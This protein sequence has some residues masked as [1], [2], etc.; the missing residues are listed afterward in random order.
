MIYLKNRKFEEAKI[1]I[2]NQ[3]E[4]TS[5]CGIV[6]TDKIEFYEQYENTEFELDRICKIC[7]QMRSFEVEEV[8][9]LKRSDVER[10]YRQDC[11]VDK[12][13]PAGCD[14]GL[15]HVVAP[16]H[17]HH[18]ALLDDWTEAEAGSQRCS[19]LLEES[20]TFACPNCN[21][22][23]M[24]QRVERRP[25]FIPEKMFKIS[26]MDSKWFLE[27]QQFSK[28]RLAAQHPQKFEEFAAYDPDNPDELPF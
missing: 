26:A 20:I 1:H 17:M 9:D 11:Y 13:T 28:Q 7:N 12:Q 21:A 6:E 16:K 22:G 10:A 3:D 25:A 4:M 24:R 2:L 8:S 5:L 23:K 18:A 27:F 15:I 19:V 14:G